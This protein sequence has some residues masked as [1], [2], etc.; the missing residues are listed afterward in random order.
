RK[1]IDKFFISLLKSRVEPIGFIKLD[2]EADYIFTDFEIK[3]IQMLLSK[4][5][6][7]L[8]NVKLYEKIKKQATED[9]LTGLYN[10]VTFQEK[11]LQAFTKKEKG[12]IGCV[13]L[14]LIDIDFF[15]K[16]NDS[17]GH[18]EGDRVL[19][20]M[21]RMLKEFSDRNKNT[22]VAR[23]GGEEF[24]FVME[25]YDINSAVKLMN[26]VRK[27]SE[28]NLKGGN[29]REQRIITLSIGVSTFPYFVSN[30]R[31]LIKSADDALY[32]AKQE[33]RNRV[34]SVVEMKNMG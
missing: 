25:D 13:S 18:Q 28:E 8:E 32:F 12:E 2:K 19:I 34:K 20:K 30:I 9:G 26:E 15:K 29:D 27:F 31:E 4:V 10:H 3:T 7:L 33:G 21:A 24:V 22:W 1:N 14:A 17:F 11:L 23:Y 6:V 5:A 16:F